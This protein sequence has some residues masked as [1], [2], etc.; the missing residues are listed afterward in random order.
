LRLT[1][2]ETK[3]KRL[4]S[5]IDETLQVS[6]DL[7]RLS[8]DQRSRLALVDLPKDWNGP[9]PSINLVSAGALNN[10]ARTVESGIFV[11]ALAARAIAR[12]NARIQAQEF[13]IHEQAFFYNRLKSERRREQERTKAKEDAE[14]AANLKAAAEKSPSFPAIEQ[15]VKDKAKKEKAVPAGAAAAPLRIERP[16]PKRRAQAVPLHPTN[17][18]PIIRRPLPP[19][20]AAQSPV[21]PG[22]D[23][24]SEGRF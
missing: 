22:T 8:L 23:P 6:L 17:H 2:K 16:S 4:D 7:D 11:N 15:T 5:G 3:P 14:R 19:P 18:P 1:P 20:A 13:D 21:L 12:E 9:P 10:P 24:L